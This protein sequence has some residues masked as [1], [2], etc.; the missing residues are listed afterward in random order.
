MEQIV[1]SDKALKEEKIN[2]W[3]Q[4][5]NPDGSYIGQYRDP[6]YA[7]FK[8]QIN[9]RANGMVD[10]LLTR[11]TAKTLF[12]K[13]FGKGFIFDM[14]DRYNLKGR[15]GLDIMGLNQEWFNKRQID[16]YRLVLS[17]QIQKILNK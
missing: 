12:P 1:L 13:P 3:E 9:P 16:V 8:N 11:Q 17:V 7:I 14:N 5:L 4:G 15:Y 10:L 6:E 2:E